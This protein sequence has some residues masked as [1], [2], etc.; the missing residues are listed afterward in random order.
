MN[1][2]YV[3]YTRKFRIEAVFHIRHHHQMRNHKRDYIKDCSDFRGYIPYP[4]ASNT[5]DHLYLDTQCLH[6]RYYT[7][8]RC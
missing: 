4:W 1:T 7:A 2:N 8:N 3:K 6:F 5:C